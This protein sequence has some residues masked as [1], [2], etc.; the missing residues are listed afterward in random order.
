MLYEHNDPGF[1]IRYA[2]TLIEG[3][4]GSGRRTRVDFLSEA[5]HVITAAERLVKA[6]K[7]VVILAEAAE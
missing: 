5:S 3:A 4:A 1:L 6:E 2:R 7:P